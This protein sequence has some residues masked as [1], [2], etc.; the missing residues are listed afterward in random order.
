M[1]S[2]PHIISLSLELWFS[3]VSTRIA[4]LSKLRFVRPLHFCRRWFIPP[5]QYRLELHRVPIFRHRSILPAHPLL[6]WPRAN[7]LR[8]MHGR[9]AFQKQS[10]CRTLYGCRE[11]LDGADLVDVDDGVYGKLKSPAQISLGICW[12]ASTHGRTLIWP[13]SRGNTLFRKR[14]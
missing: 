9:R 7:S 14:W 4:S 12:A 5:F 2:N 10:L 8:K 3:R 11:I 6:S 1:L 13:S